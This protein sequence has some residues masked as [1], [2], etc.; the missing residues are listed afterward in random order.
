LTCPISCKMIRGW[1]KLNWIQLNCTGLKVCQTLGNVSHLSG[2]KMMVINYNKN[3]WNC[4]FLLYRSNFL[5]LNVMYKLYSEMWY[6]HIIYWYIKTFRYNFW[7][8]RRTNYVN[9]LYGCS[10]TRADHLANFNFWTP[11]KPHLSFPIYGFPSFNVQFPPF[12]IFDNLML[13]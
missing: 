11:V 5:N 8:S 2:F 7:V 9:M 1:N 13:S 12:Q 6:L 3:N 10:Y 4:G